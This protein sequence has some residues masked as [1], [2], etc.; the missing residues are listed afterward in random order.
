MPEA[1]WLESRCHCWLIQR[2]VVALL[3]L[4]RRDVA[5]RLQQP[6]IVEPVDPFQRREL[7]GLERPPR[8]TSMDDLGLVETVDGFGESIVLGISDTADRRLDAGLSQALGVFDRDVL[9][10]SVA[11]M[12]EP[13]AMQWPPVMQSL[14]QRVEHEARVR[15]L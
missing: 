1:V 2:G 13:T 11:V 4:G 6:A 9:A 10:A 15:C 14:F 7:D 8:P 5:D 12:H 3:G